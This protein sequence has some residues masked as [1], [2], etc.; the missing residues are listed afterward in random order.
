MGGK[1]RRSFSL[2]RRTQKSLALRQ[3]DEAA[4][5]LCW[6]FTFSPCRRTFAVFVA[7]GKVESCRSA[8]LIYVVRGLPRKSIKTRPPGWL[9]ATTGGLVSC[10]GL[11]CLPRMDFW[12]G[13]EAAAQERQRG[14]RARG[15]ENQ[16]LVGFFFHFHFEVEVSM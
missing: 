12:D 1:S 8:P 3:R 10:V 15:R 11:D 4:P 13:E 6:L 7:A 14:G 5:F 9:P 2:F 16:F